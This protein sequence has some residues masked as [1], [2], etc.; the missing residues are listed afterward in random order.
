MP[1]HLGS[2]PDS[3][4]QFL[5]PVTCVAPAVHPAVRQIRYSREMAKVAALTDGLCRYMLR[6][7]T[8]EERVLAELRAETSQKLGDAAGM[9]VSEEQGVLLRMLVASLK[10]KLVVE[11]G[12]FTGYSAICMASALS[13]GAKLICC[14]VNEESTQI[15]AAYCQRCGFGDRIDLRIAPALTTIET[16]PDTVALDFVFI[17]ADKVN[18]VAYYEALLPRMRS[19]GLIVADNVMWHNWIMDASN[20][21]PETIGIR[22]FNDHVRRDKRVESVMLHVGDGLTLIRKL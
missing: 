11:V 8:A 19:D 15:A 12:T 6:H 2:H 21:D 16:L 9:M 17:D 20:Q 7:R 10:P 22:E 13:P 1:R 14:D 3:G 5:C 4:P 18:Y